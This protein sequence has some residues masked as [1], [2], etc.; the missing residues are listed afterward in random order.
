MRFLRAA[1]H[2]AK[3]TSGATRGLL[4]LAVDEPPRRAPR[5]FYKDY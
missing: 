3:F 1:Q 5:Q 2:A 4:V